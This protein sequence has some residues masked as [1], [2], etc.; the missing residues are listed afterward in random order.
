M[1]MSSRSKRR[2][3]AEEVEYSKTS[4]PQLKNNTISPTS[5]INI[6]VENPITEFEPN[7]YNNE[8]VMT[9]TDKTQAEKPIQK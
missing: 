6:L 2:R 1:S 5:N 9:S 4:L 7:R 3:I 8:V